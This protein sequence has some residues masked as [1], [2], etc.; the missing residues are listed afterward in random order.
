MALGLLATTHY[1]YSCGAGLL[2]MEVVSSNSS[3]GGH[4]CPLA[5][6][7]ITLAQYSALVEKYGMVWYS[8]ALVQYL[9]AVQHCV[10]PNHILRS[11]VRHVIPYHTI[12]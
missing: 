7:V 8:R 9:P 6:S 3:G 10:T 2:V 11:A 4:R 12:P 5:S 1:L